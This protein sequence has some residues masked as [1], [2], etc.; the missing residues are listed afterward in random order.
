MPKHF[1]AVPRI[2]FLLLGKWTEF[3]GIFLKF[4]ETVF[5]SKCLWA[6]LI[7]LVP[8]VWW[9]NSS[10]GTGDRPW[11]DSSTILGYTGK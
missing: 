3:I 2:Y 7:G 5:W 4:W 10:P 9:V 1:G 11:T 6:G 8:G